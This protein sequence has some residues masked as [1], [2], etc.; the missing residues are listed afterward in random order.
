MDS[1]TACGPDQAVSSS[2]L[3]AAEAASVWRYDHTL[4]SSADFRR[5]LGSGRRSGRAGLTVVKAP[6]S[7][8]FPRVGLVVGRKVGNA[9]RRNRAKR[10]LRHALTS[11]PLEQGMDY[12]IIAGPQVVDAP[13]TD[14]CRWLAA[15]IRDSR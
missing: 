14:L 9:V 8:P 2:A 4:T 1:D 13:F 15:A 7:A 3:D 11:T 6:G 12:V 10:R 5:V